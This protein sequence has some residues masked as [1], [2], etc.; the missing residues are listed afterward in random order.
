MNLDPILSTPVAVFMALAAAMMWGT[1]FISLKHLDDYPVE[2]FYITLFATSL[3]VVWGAGML[4]DGRALFSNIA[5]VFRISPM[6]IIGT[7][8]CGVLYASGLDLTLRV[9]RMIGLTLS[10]PL[11][12]SLNLMIGTVVTTVIGGWPE[13]LTIPRLLA[14]CVF[15]IL[16]VVLVSFAERRKSR[17]QAAADEGPEAKKGGSI[18]RRAIVLLVISSLFQTGYSFG[19]SYGL[20][21]VT[22]PVGMAVM[23]FMC[24]L[25]TGAF[26]GVMLTNGVTL[27]RK[28]QWN[29]LFGAPFRVHKWGIFSGCFHYGGNIIHTFATRNLSSAITFPLGLTCGLWTQLWGLRYGEFRGA[30]M[31]AYVLQFSSFACYILGAV[32]ITL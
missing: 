17:G 21:S 30:P 13:G 23:P 1:W 8:I 5:E 29:R 14:S 32:F 9:M 6:K 22:Q 2:A 27:T 12:Q 25:C 28:K 3:V 16:A 4:L 7:L 10:Q 19:I 31:S 11:Q 15:L 26:I 24:I 18:M 20:K